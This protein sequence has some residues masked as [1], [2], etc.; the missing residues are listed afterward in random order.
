MINFSGFFENFTLQDS[1]HNATFP[2]LY[3]VLILDP[4][5]GFPLIGQIVSLSSNANETDNTVRSE[6]GLRLKSTNKGP[7]SRIVLNPVSKSLHNKFY[8]F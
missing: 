1:L 2:F 6:I 5:I 3:S 7:I 4:L 8:Y